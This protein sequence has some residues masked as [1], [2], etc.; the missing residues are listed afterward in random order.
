MVPCINTIGEHLMIKILL[1]S[2]IIFFVSNAFADSSNAA[3]QSGEVF[4]NRNVLTPSAQTTEKGTLIYT[5]HNIVINGLSYGLTDTTEI[6]F[7]SFFLFMSALM[8]KQKLYDDNTFRVA[9]LGSGSY[10]YL[11]YAGMVGGTAGIVCDYQV[12]SD[13]A[14]S[15]YCHTAL[16]WDF[17]TGES[18]DI[19]WA[20][21]GNYHGLAGGS[22]NWKISKKFKLHVESD[23]VESYVFDKLS[24]PSLALAYGIRYSS[25]KA[26][27]ELLMV[28]AIT[29]P[30]ENRE[31]MW[32]IGYPIFS[33][34][35][36][37]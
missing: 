14:F 29:L 19:T 32:P 24:Q 20:S 34:A 7:E 11:F 15:F 1:S 12:M 18:S 10:G 5:T 8:V 9:I 2:L 17:N 25:G 27:L 23:I 6:T 22:A 16:I 30:L 35:Y 37:F 36:K 13:L 3:G 21:D 31:E 28:K 33:T 4:A 26:G